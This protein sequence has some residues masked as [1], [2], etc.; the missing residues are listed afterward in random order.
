MNE[1]R[2]VKPEFKISLVRLKYL[3]IFIELE[4]F[5]LKKENYIHLV[6]I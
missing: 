3:E 5:M 2:S 1:N 6:L 4:I